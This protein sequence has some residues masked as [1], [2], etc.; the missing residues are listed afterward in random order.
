V[1]LKFK[2]LHTE[3]PILFGCL[4]HAL[5]NETLRHVTNIITCPK[6]GSTTTVDSLDYGLRHVERGHVV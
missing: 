6:E 3:P 2:I 1:V 5:G 4:N